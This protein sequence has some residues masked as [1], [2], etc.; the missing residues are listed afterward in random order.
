[1]IQEGKIEGRGFSGALTSPRGRRQSGGRH[2]GEAPVK[3]GER[4]LQAWVAP[5][6]GTNYVGEQYQE[7]QRA[8]ARIHIPG[9]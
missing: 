3:G 8:L 5:D 6:R 4:S 7:G 1:M 2:A 9:S